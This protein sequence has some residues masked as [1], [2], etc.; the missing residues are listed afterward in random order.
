MRWH[1]QDVQAAVLRNRMIKAMAHHHLQSKAIRPLRQ[2]KKPNSRNRRRS[3]RK[4]Q[5]RPSGKTSRGL[6][7]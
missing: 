7:K 4:L 5:K 1:Y 6:E 3:T 2:R